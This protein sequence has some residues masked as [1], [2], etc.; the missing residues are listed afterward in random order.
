VIEPD[1][2]GETFFS[3]ATE[4]GW[5]YSQIGEMTFPQLTSW[6]RKGKSPTPQVADP[7]QIRALVAKYAEMN[8]GQA[9]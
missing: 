4:T 8:R 1:D 7:A 5:T 9:S 2:W 3:I 6:F